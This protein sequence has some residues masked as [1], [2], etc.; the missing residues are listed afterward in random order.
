MGSGGGGGSRHYPTGLVVA[1][2]LGVDSWGV[3]VAAGAVGGAAHL[4]G[5]GLAAGLLRPVGYLG[6]GL[7]SRVGGGVGGVLVTLLHVVAGCGGHGCCRGRR[8]GRC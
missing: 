1:L 4:G 5:G 6:A 2:G 3:L 7:F 8:L